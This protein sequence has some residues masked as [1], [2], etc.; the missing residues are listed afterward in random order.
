MAARSAAP[1]VLPLPAGV[2]AFVAPTHWRAIDFIS[3][4]HLRES[5]PCL[6]EAWAAHMRHTT[7]DAVFILGDLFD[8]WVGDDAAA[9]G[10][11]AR[12]AEVLAEASQRLGVAFMVGNRDF[13]V[14]SVLL[15]RSSVMQ[16]AD[17]TL[18]EA[19]G[20]KVLVSHGDALCI[21][22]LAYQRYRRL[23]DRRGMQRAFA[24]LPLSVRRRIGRALRSNSRSHDA[25]IVAGPIAD[26]DA[27]SALEWARAAR[28]PSLIH[29][30]THVPADHTMAPG[31]TRRVLSDWELDDTSRPRAEVLR[32]SAAGFAR[33]PP[34]TG[35]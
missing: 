2:P 15:R 34:A 24:L 1:A 29:G 11:E 13:L 4:L 7:A 14:G 12:C 10:F 33:L 21:D 16:L 35:A 9:S 22:D 3:D 8:M 18:V 6:F 20:T 28:A 25:P 32:W 23:V 27:A 31:I 5:S 17:P 30:H 26:V 19:F